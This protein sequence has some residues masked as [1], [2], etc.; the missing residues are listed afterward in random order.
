[1]IG[2]FFPLL[3]IIFYGVGI[4]YPSLL[5][6]ASSF[7]WMFVGHK[8]FLILG[9]VAAMVLATPLS[10]LPQRR[11]R[12]VVLLLIVAAVFASSIWPFLAPMFNRKQLAQLWK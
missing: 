3:L 10:R 12:N 2:Y 9:F 5:S 8:K 7:S 1:M 4:H 6:S 11:D